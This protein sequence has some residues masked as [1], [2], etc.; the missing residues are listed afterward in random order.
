VADDRGWSVD[1]QPVPALHA[2]VKVPSFELSTQQWKG[3]RRMNDRIFKPKGSRIYRWRFRQNPQEGKILDMSL[4][5]SELRV[6]EKRAAE[7]R[8]KIQL[9]RAGLIPPQKTLESAQRDLALHLED[10]LGDMLRRGKSEK[11]LANLEF[12]VGRMIK[13]CHWN[14]AASVTADS[15]QAWLRGKSELS[16]KT[17]NDYLEAVRCFFNWLIKMERFSN[18]PL[19]RVEKVKTAGRQTRERRAFTAEELKRLLGVAGEYKTA[20]LM[21]AHTGLRRSE[22]ANL[23]WAD[24]HLDEAKPFALVR[25]STTKNSLVA[26]MRL[27]PELARALLEYKTES[28]PGD[29]VFKRFPRIERFKLDLAKAKIA[30]QDVLG[31]YADFHALR[32]TFGTNLAKAGVPRRTAMSLMRH[33]DGKLT[34]KI[35]TDEN[36][37][38]MD[39]TIE[40][41][42]SFLPPA[43]LLASLE[44]GATG[45]YATSAVTT[46]DGAKT[47]KSIVFT[48]ESH[49]LTPYVTTGHENKDGGSGG[50]RTRNLCRDRAAL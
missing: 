38:G 17:A 42:P 5:T 11:Y 43:S 37:L 28:Q 15:F 8:S 39:S 2:I 44:M 32:K 46:G 18:N 26:P 34:D 48:G 45:H 33:S 25:A 23:M 21:A 6:A 30:Y 1:G 19:A 12:R 22:L 10:F 40:G 9:E 31:R 29:L 49:V 35:Y 7:L 24:L 14:T 47:Y 16:A 13:E 36:L 20:Y 3:R 41:M 27:H 50:A 4:G